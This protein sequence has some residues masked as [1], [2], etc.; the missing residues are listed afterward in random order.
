MTKDRI[1]LE[2]VILYGIIFVKVTQIRVVSFESTSNF[3]KMADKHT[4]M[5]DKRSKM[6]DKRR[7]E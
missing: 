1:E 6:A 2:F 3:Y 5:A 7:F 4:K